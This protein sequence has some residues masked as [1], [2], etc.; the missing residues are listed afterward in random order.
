MS[1]SSQTH[2]MRHFILRYLLLE[3]KLKNLN[4]QNGFSVILWELTYRD[5]NRR[6]TA[7]SCN[8]EWYAGDGT[9]WCS[10]GTCSRLDSCCFLHLDIN[11]L[12]PAFSIFVPCPLC[13]SP[14]SRRS[15]TPTGLR[16][17]TSRSLGSRRGYLLQATSN[18]IDSKFLKE[19]L[20]LLMFGGNIILG[21]V[22]LCT[23]Y[24][25]RL[26]HTEVYHVASRLFHSP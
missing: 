11:T 16:E 13:R 26:L 4:L 12:V 22:Y 2:S 23:S 7:H 25:P 21:I 1:K 3:N 15:P 17:S 5:T 8:T 18:R 24:D 10:C 6:S 9:G 14:E 20:Q 19:D